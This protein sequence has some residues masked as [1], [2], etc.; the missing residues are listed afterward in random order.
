MGELWSLV[1]KSFPEHPQNLYKVLFVDRLA[2]GNSMDVD[3]TLVGKW[4][5][6]EF[7]DGFS[8][9]ALL[10]AGGARMFPLGN[11]SLGV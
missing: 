4:D 9:P 10:M 5:Q 6:H 7:H 1:T 3:D 2:R 11:L 8:L